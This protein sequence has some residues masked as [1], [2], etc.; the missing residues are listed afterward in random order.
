M[1]V[2]SLR[3]SSNELT[4]LEA[5]AKRERMKLGTWIKRAAMI[6]A[7]RVNSQTLP[8]NNPQLLPITPPDFEQ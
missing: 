4:A 7:E 6:D 1:K 8:E 3:L 5:A 2:I